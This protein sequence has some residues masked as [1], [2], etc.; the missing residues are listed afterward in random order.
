MDRAIGAM[1]DA[2]GGKFEN[3]RNPERAGCGEGEF[4]DSHHAAP[5]CVRK[6]AQLLAR[7]KSISRAE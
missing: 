3:L 7:E 5:S 4:E 2:S 6:V 1:A